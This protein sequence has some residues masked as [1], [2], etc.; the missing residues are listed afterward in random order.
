MPV[1]PRLAASLCVGLLAAGCATS[2]SVAQ[3][4]S[5]SATALPSPL[6]SLPT[7]TPVVLPAPP[8]TAIPS[9]TPLVCHARG[10]LPDPVCTPGGVDPRVTQADIVQTICVA[11]WTARVRPPTSYTD[12]L[13]RQQIAEYGY[14][15]RAVAD[16]SEDHLVPLSLGGAPTDPHNLWPEARSPQP[17]AL[18]KDR[19]EDRAHALVCSGQMSLADARRDIAQDWVTMYR[20]WVSP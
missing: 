6:P 7:V 15:D 4:V 19:L 8:A 1:V 17:G 2:P 14:A 9:P 20:H 10:P 3:P 16:Y 18:E 12:P 11:G 5:P 13:K